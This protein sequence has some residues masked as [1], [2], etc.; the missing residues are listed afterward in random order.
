MRLRESVVRG[1]FVGSRDGRRALLNLR[2]I[3]RGKIKHPVTRAT[4]AMQHAIG[5][6]EIAARVSEIL[7]VADR[8]D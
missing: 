8:V 4:G 3:W 7:V 2:Y 6:P 5:E 1:G